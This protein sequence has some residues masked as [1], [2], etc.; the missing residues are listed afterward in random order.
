M[1]LLG[2]QPEPQGQVPALLF[3]WGET[4]SL[5]LTLSFVVLFGMS[6]LMS[7]KHP[8]FISN[9]IFLFDVHGRFS[10]SPKR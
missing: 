4:G 2:E 10:T 6:T 3:P 5:H 1:G 9:D 8:L 7:D